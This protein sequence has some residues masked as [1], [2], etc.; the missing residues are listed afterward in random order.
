[1]NGN[2]YANSK[3]KIF[4]DLGLG[5]V[6]TYVDEKGVVWFFYEWYCKNLRY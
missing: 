3:Y 6:R 2:I 5:D 1:M 4:N